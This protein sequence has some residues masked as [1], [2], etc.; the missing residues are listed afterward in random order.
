MDA[1]IFC[2]ILVLPCLVNLRLELAVGGA[3]GGAGAGIAGVVTANQFLADLL[4]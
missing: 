4:L 1:E 2:E 3:G